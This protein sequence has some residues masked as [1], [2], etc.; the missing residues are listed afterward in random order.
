MPLTV[1]QVQNAKAGRH[2]DGNGLYL[3]VKPSGSK[4]WVL[5]VQHI[6]KRQDFGLGSVATDPIEVSIPSDFGHL[7]EGTCRAPG[8]KGRASHHR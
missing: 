1:K 2:S 7:R 6:G 8:D 5:R 3:L 4:S